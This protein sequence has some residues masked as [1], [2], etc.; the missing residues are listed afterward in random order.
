MVLVSHVSTI[1]QA[2]CTNSRL[3][4]SLQHLQESNLITSE[5]KHLYGLRLSGGIKRVNMPRI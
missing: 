3:L 1:L 2:K 4:K 5:N